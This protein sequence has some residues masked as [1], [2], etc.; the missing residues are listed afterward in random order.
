MY[1]YVVTHFIR[2]S[3]KNLS[4]SLLQGGNAFTISWNSLIL[5]SF[6][7]IAGEE[8]EYLLIYCYR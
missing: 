2:C 5:A 8:T 7:F 6:G 4:V 1:D 3:S